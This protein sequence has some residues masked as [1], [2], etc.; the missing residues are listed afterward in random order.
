MAQKWSVSVLGIDLSSSLELFAP[1]VSSGIW[2]GQLVCAKGGSMLD[3][4]QEIRYRSC[5]C[6]CITA[7]ETRRYLV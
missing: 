5:T 6:R 3:V 7:I 2:A 4:N 1:S